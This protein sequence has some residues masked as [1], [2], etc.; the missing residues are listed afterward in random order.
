MEAVIFQDK[1]IETL[2]FSNGCGEGLIINPGQNIEFEPKEMMVA[3]EILIPGR[4]TSMSGFFKNSLE[5]VGVV[6]E[7]SLLFRIGEEINLFGIKEYYQVIHWITETRLF[8][9][10]TYHSG[11]DFNFINGK[12]K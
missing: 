2:I 7:S 5:Y 11:R 1:K 8:S 4:F 10:Y 12:W 6:N 3:D 9:M